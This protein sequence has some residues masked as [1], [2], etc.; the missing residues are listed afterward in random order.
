MAKV[1]PAELSMEML[2]LF[3]PKI[4]MLNATSEELMAGK[5]F[6]EGFTDKDSNDIES[7][8][9]DTPEDREAANRTRVLYKEGV[10][11]PMHLSTRVLLGLKV[12]DN[13]DFDLSDEEHVAATKPLYKI[14]RDGITGNKKTVGFPK[15]FTIVSVENR[16]T[17][18]KNGKNKVVRPFYHYSEFSQ[19]MDQISENEPNL[20]KRSKLQ[21]AVF[22]DFE[23]M[24]GL[25]G[26]EIKPRYKDAE[27]V[28]NL[29]IML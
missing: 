18:N 25:H 12:T 4:G 26:G 2:N 7:V 29:V 19:K 8:D 5:F 14:L 6:Y 21:D 16:V 10:E 1:K 27:A 9:T 20:K 28:K 22:Q 15:E 23:F 24:N 3:I 17:D 13:K 11:N